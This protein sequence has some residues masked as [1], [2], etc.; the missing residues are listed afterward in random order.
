MQY[1]LYFDPFKIQNSSH[2]TEQFQKTEK[3]TLNRKFKV[4]GVD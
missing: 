1:K 3:F 2:S 4:L